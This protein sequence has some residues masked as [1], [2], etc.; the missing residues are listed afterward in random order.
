MGYWAQMRR[1]VLEYVA[2][3]GSVYVGTAT[4]RRGRR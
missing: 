4:V 2:E 1:I 3:H